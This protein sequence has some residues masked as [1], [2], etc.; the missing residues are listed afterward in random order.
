MK[1][2]WLKILLPFAVKKILSQ[3]LLDRRA[4]NKIIFLPIKEQTLYIRLS[5]IYSISTIRELVAH[6]KRVQ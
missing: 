2:L 4:F 3:T 1:S 5:F 6:M